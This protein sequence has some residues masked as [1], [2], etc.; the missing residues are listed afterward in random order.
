M[1]KYYDT[2]RSTMDLAKLLDG[3][4]GTV[5]D[6]A[7]P[8]GP[9]PY[10]Q[11]P[12]PYVSRQD[13]NSVAGMGTFGRLEDLQAQGFNTQTPYADI[14][15]IGT[16]GGGGAGFHPVGYIDQ[17][18]SVKISSGERGVIAAIPVPPQDFDWEPF[19]VQ[20]KVWMP[21]DPIP[22]VD[23]VDEYPWIIFKDEPPL[24]TKDD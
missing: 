10:A 16:G 9:N 18:T 13:P 19:V 22:G 23:D 11:S 20:G 5:P 4:D 7:P 17:V 15:L 24:H 14:K 1:Q 12:R 3:Y 8:I 21:T 2:R 6:R